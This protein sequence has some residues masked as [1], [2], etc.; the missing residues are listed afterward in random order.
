ML[1][2]EIVAYY[3]N[4]GKTLIDVLEDFYKKYGYYSDKT[5][6]ITYE[7]IEGAKKISRIMEKIRDVYPKKIGESKIKMITDYL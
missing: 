5:I 7:G 4:K 1:L 2:V 3:K 6:S